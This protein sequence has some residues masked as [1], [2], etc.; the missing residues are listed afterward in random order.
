MP[1]SPIAAF[2]RTFLF[3]P[4]AI[5]LSAAQAAKAK[6]ILKGRSQEL[7]MIE[8]RVIDEFIVDQVCFI[9]SQLSIYVNKFNFL[10]KGR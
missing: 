4:T 5:E 9:L 3:V 6:E 1:A 10:K 2:L 7:P 8:E